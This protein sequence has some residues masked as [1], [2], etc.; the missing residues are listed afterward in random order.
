MTSRTEASGQ[1]V[2]APGTWTQA[3]VAKRP[4][5]V[6]RV[7]G[8]YV[9]AR[10]RLMIVPVMPRRMRVIEEEVGGGAEAETGRHVPGLMHIRPAR[11]DA[12]RHALSQSGVKA[13]A[14]V[15]QLPQNSAASAPWVRRVAKAET[16]ARRY[17]PTSISAVGF[18]ARGWRLLTLRREGLVSTAGEMSRQRIKGDVG[19]TKGLMV[20]YEDVDDKAL[21]VERERARAA[22]RYRVEAYR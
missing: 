2:E 3:V 8:R 1:V 5:W 12:P 9:P 15:A 14:E 11:P 20:E 17:S 18:E 19:A 16:G 22:R 10:T 13:A 21:M 7:T 6:D 4:E